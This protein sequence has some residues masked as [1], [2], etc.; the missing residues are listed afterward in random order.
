MSAP[1]V[2]VSVPVLV[3]R[4]MHRNDH[5]RHRAFNLSHTTADENA[6][7]CAQLALIFARQERWWRVLANWTSR[8]ESE[9]PAIAGRAA[10]YAAA[11]AGSDARFWREMAQYWHARAAGL[12]D[13][14]ANEST[15]WPA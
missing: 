5:D 7:R 3:E 4:A 8:A 9:L 2:P 14:E 15:G 13:A 10:I 11:Q 12:S 1:T 6:R